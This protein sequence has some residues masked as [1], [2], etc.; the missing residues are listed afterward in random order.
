MRSRASFLTLSFDNDPALAQQAIRLRLQ[1]PTVTAEMGF[2]LA[3][4]KFFVPGF[5]LSGAHPIPFHSDDM[6]LKVSASA[7]CI[8][9]Y[10][11]LVAT[12]RQKPEGLMTLV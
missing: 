8:L 12:S 4:T 2:M 9:D 1:R 3:V 11:I 10:S 7:N 6:L 5:A